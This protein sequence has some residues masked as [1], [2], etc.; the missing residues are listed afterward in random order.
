MTAGDGDDEY[1]AADGYALFGNVVTDIPDGAYN[2]V[3]AEI[4]DDS[5]G[6]IVF[7]GRN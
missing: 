5:D 1:I 2:E 4:T 6:E 7:T 3:R